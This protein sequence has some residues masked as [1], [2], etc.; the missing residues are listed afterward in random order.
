MTAVKQDE[1]IEFVIESAREH[2]G[3]GDQ[4]CSELRLLLKATQDCEHELIVIGQKRTDKSVHATQ[5][6]CRKCF[7]QIS[8]Y[9]LNALQSLNLNALKSLNM[10]HMKE[11][12]DGQL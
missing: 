4:G 2:E 12:K 5:F 7:N 9:A 10:A 11:E 1:L 6:M 3:L 8:D